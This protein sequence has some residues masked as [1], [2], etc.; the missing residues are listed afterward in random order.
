[1]A[2]QAQDTFTADLK[3]G[4]T[5]RVV[6]GEVYADRHELVVRDAEGA[7]AAR[8]A[9][10]DRPALFKPLDLGEDEAPV[11]PRASGKAASS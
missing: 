10:V 11:K 7:A 9:G 8:K 6:K 5:V 3:D 2:M 4:T 1:M